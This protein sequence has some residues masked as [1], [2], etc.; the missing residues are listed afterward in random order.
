MAR[1]SA[2]CSIEGARFHTVP[3]AKVT[4]WIEN[5]TSS[6]GFLNQ[7]RMN[8]TPTAP[9][10]LSFKVEH[11]GEEHIYNLTGFQGRLRATSICYAHARQNAPSRLCMACPPTGHLN[12]PV[13]HLFLA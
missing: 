2:L 10:Y 3:S 13:A 4:Y 11:T 5:H 9:N 7:P 12:Q 6:T 1:A 8:F